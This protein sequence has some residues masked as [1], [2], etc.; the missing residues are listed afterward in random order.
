MH[1]N[2]SVHVGLDR[3]VENVTWLEAVIYCNERTDLA[4]LTRA[5]LIVGDTVIWDREADGFRLPTEAEWERS[6]RAG[7]TTAFAT[8]PIEKE[9]CEV[10]PV[11]DAI[12]W[13][14]GN[15]GDGPHPVK[16]KPQANA[17]GLFDMHGNVWEYCWDWYE[18]P[19]AGISGDGGPSTGA[20]RVI[21]GGSWYYYA[22]ECRSASRAP[23][24]PNS[25][26]DIVGF[27]VARTIR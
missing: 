7:S 17:F 3:P 1:T 26:D 15:A 20:Q 27:R 9:T 22:R 19:T 12:G 11:L 13:Y 6:C 18:I 5:Y 25:K 10:D 24:W 4:G 16:S 21:R 14:C 23:Y 2:P 8:G